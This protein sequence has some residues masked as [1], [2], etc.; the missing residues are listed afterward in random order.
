MFWRELKR[1]L[2]II[3]G[4]TIVG[5]ALNSFIV[6]NRIADGGVTGASIILHY[7]Y[8][9][10][11]GWL[12]AI[13][14]V[15]VFLVG[16]RFIGRGFGLRSLLG[17]ISVSLAVELT[18]G[19]PLVTRDLL[20]ASVFGGAINGIGMGI[21]LRAQG[22]LG[23]T[24]I[25]AI[26]FSRLFGFTIGEILLGAD[27]VILTA[28]GIVFRSVELAMYAMITMFVAAKVVDVIQEG[29]NHSKTVIIIS[30]QVGEIARAI[31]TQ[32]ER[33]V[34]FLHGE[35]GYS[36]E[37]KRVIFCV[38]TRAEIA[39]LKEIVWGIDHNAFVTV[40]DAHEVLGEGFKTR[41]EF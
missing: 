12:I 2:A 38:I 4:S 1:A 33:G 3:L 30:N 35:G 23:G 26:V 15:P 20:L 24:D 10:P 39:R 17:V 19:L 40:A 34:T 36:G 7:L 5:V 25:L 14:N 6:P 21:V 41:G 16:I 29:L 22:S 32:L 31:L 28:A 9:F 13:I 27:V 37:P 8:G 18:R 11:I